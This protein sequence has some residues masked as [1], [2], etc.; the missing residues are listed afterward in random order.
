[1]TAPA[2]RRVRGN[3]RPSWARWGGVLVAVAASLAAL[4]LP[5]GAARAATAPT[6]DQMTGVG[7]TA[8]AVTADW[9]QG[10]LDNNNQPIASANADRTSATPSSPDSFMYSD[11]KT[12][13][14][15]VSQTQDIGHQG[16][17]V[18]WT[19]GQPTDQLGG[20]I[21]A[22]FL[23]MMECWGDASTGPDPEQCEY[24]SQGVLASNALNQ[25][26]D[27]RTGDLCTA[28][29]VA[30]TDPSQTPSSV[31]GDPSYFGCDP[32][33]P[34]DPSHL[35]PCPSSSDSST[36]TTACPTVCPDANTTASCDVSF[37]VPFE[38]VSDP[39]TLDWNTA[40][41]TYYNEFSTDEVPAAV[42]AADG[43]GQ[44][45]FE[46]LTGTQA[47][48]LGCGEAESDG[49]ARGCW[50][51]IVPRGKY[52]PNGFPVSTDTA[53]PNSFLNTSPLSKSN[54][55]QRI[56]IHLGFAPVG[57]FCP[58]GTLER[59]TFGTQVIARAMQSWQLALNQ[60]AD[61]NKVY[62]Y[63]AVTESESTLNLTAGGDS[64]LAFTTI[65]IGSE[66]ARDGT[67]P[68]TNLPNIVYAPVAIAALDF[69]FNIDDGGGTVTTPVKLTP[70]L[71][72][73][74][75]TQSY[76]DDLPDFHPGTG[77]AGPA[78]VQ[79]NPLNISEDPQFQTLNPE[80]HPIADYSLA[81]L[82]TEDHSALN[83][84]VWQWIQAD[85]TTTG[86]LGGTKDSTDGNMVVDPDYQALNLGTPPA[87]DSFPRAY[88]GVLSLC[89][90]TP[91]G[92]T[93]PQDPNCPAG[94]QT[95]Q[96]HSLD[97]LPYI[98][99]Y[100]AAA[101]AV[102]HANDSD[103]TGGWDTGIQ[104]PSNT[105]G[106][107]D[108][109]GVQTLGQIFMWAAND[110]P[111]L[112]AYG[113]VPAQLCNDAGTTCLSPSTASVTAAV[114]AATADSSGL[115][116]VNPANPG[117]GAYPLTQVI[118]AAVP[119]NQ[120]AAALTDYANLISYAVGTGQ[121]PGATPGDLPPGYLPL[122]SNLVTQAQSVV[123]QLQN[124]ATA[125]PS[126][127][128][129]PTSSS[130]GQSTGTGTTTSTGTGTGSTTSAASTTGSTSTS[131][132]TSGG[133][134]AA[135]LT[136][137]STPTP[138]PAGN[139]APTSAP[140]TT[141]ASGLATTPVTKNTSR[142]ATGIGA[143]T[144]GSTPTSLPPVQQAAGTQPAEAVGAIRWVL[145]G[146]AVIGAGFAGGGTLLSSG[147]LPPWR[148]R[149]LL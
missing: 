145:V 35:A 53:G 147:G 39:T 32:Q 40:D 116:E 98:D 123:A 62:G 83:Q 125:S 81:P 114:N 31:D 130:S 77:Q 56:Q 44:Q 12:L 97:L 5:S 104:S 1:M 29:A 19:G 119:T 140:V 63:S 15:T 101:S 64:G 96:K 10:L 120:S 102:L 127:S 16:I 28:G 46:T 42:T 74:A 4:S 6:Y 43:T 109:A 87:L 33:E 14:V 9:T 11:F 47:P 118:Y 85:S 99:N 91:T 68:P 106:W 111:D 75:V 92:S 52:E 126:P 59:Q 8:S 54:W 65:P 24:G 112:A 146:V 45:Q 21:Q 23:Q 73:K 41:T 25:V 70:L 93:A 66:A 3:R 86:W 124:L 30:S 137:G 37:T 22:N 110:T 141:P 139:T 100:D 133:T 67:S 149:R 95:E 50:L 72:A 82:L 113:L 51:V 2:K 142:A 55:D 89:E 58:P 17:S 49:S 76:S 105:V 80:V 108:K 79:G 122:P 136:A 88:T 134:G 94:Q 103:E 132:G 148:R 128:T 26:I 20:T 84:Q 131:T 78:W 121:T 57:S 48:G 36:D 135:G 107:W 115:L 69:G 38:P 138:A 90:P 60:A 144:P 27:E 18:S 7:P 117:S 143:S 13:Q 61:C 129:S 34:S 71:L